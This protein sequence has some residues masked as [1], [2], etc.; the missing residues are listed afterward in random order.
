MKKVEKLRSTNWLSYSSHG[1]VG[2]SKRN[3]VSD[4]VIATDGVGWVLDLSG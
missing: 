2:Y 3:T 1:N 4:T